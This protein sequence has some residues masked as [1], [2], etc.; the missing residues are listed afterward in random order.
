MK[1]ILLSASLLMLSTAAFAVTDGQTYNPTDGFTCENVWVFD[2]VHTLDD[3]QASAICS[4]QS[5]TAT[6][7]DK[8]IYV[9]VNGLDGTGTDGG[10]GQAVIHVYDLLTGNL[11]CGYRNRCPYIGRR[12]VVY[13]R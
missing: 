5:R 10:Y 12:Y 6:I 4:T 2:R 11:F 3:Y 1:K 9:I 13:G 8:N 7:D